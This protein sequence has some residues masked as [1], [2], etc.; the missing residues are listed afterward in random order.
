MAV[1]R[2][3]AG[4]FVQVLKAQS[5]RQAKFGHHN[6][7]TNYIQAGVNSRRGPIRFYRLILRNARKVG[8]L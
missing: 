8:E 4:R 6:H 5:M 1:D 2:C 7:V 3:K